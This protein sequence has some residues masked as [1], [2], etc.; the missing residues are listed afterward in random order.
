MVL[1]TS[2]DMLY[3]IDANAQKLHNLSLAMKGSSMVA[4]RLERRGKASSKARSVENLKTK[5]KRML[6]KSLA[7]DCANI[8]GPNLIDV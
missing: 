4:S 2:L 8:R 5:G 7:E 6:P 1:L 3:K